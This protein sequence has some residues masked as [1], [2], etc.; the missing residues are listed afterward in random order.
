MSP[1]ATLRVPRPRPRAAVKGAGRQAAQRVVERAGAGIARLDGARV[2]H[3][4]LV[5]AVNLL[6]PY[7]FIADRAGDLDSKMV[8]RILDPRGGAPSESTVLISDR[9]CAVVP[10]ADPSARVSITAGIDDLVRLVSGEVGWP[11]LVSARRMVLWGDP[12]LALR[13]PM[14]FGVEKGAGQSALFGLVRR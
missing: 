6:I 2:A 12:Y 14:L 13:F 9:R 8:L 7:L 10:G 5:Q 4:L 3:P 11:Q 1:T